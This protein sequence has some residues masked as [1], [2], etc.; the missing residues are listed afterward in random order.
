MNKCMYRKTSLAAVLAIL[1]LFPFGQ[2]DASG[3]TLSNPVTYKTEVKVK[4]LPTNTFSLKINGL[5]EIVNLDNNTIIPYSFLSVT[6]KDGALQILTASESFT[7]VK[8]IDINEIQYSA[9]NDVEVTGINTAQGVKPVKY[10]GSMEIRPGSGS[11]PPTLFN[12]LDM[13]DYLKGVVPSEMPA[14]WH[15][16]ALKAQSVAARSYAHTQIQSNKAKGYL[17]MTVSNQVYGGKSSEHANSNK[18]IEATAGIFATYNNVPINAVF[19]SSS[20]GHTENSENVWSS[21]VPYIKAVPD[22]YDVNTSHYGW[23]TTANADT[24][25]KSLGLNADQMLLGLEVTKRG[26]SSA[27]QQMQA[28]IYNRSTDSITKMDLLPKYATTPDRFRSIFGTSLKSIKFDVS[29]DSSHKIRLANGKDESTSYLTGYKIKDASGKEVTV[30]D[31]NLPVKT[32]S[33]SKLVPTG[34]KTFTFSGDGWGHLLGMSQWGAKG[35]AES[36]HSYDQILKHY[37]TGIEVKKMN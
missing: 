1:L 13:E 2:A 6:Q 37:Y 21:A 7:S 35:M 4:L 25:K 23:S 20:G 19:H 36:G 28:S 34:P 3:T 31:L 27:V 30:E 26:P 15:L 17:E 12:I 10:R 18:A 29:V 5:Y 32:A 14:S 22:P 16:E 33:S 8:G 24:I 9:D 11:T